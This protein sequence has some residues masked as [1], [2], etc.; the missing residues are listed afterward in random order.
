M[1]KASCVCKQACRSY[2]EGGLGACRFV[3][4]L[5]LSITY[6]SLEAKFLIGYTLPLIRFIGA[7]PTGQ[8]TTCMIIYILC[9]IY[10]F[11]CILSNMQHYVL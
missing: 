1:S 11:D 2:G 8:M 9:E 4:C 6:S 5:S 7:S 3:P 10:A